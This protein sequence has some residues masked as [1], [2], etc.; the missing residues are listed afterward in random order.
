VYNKSGRNIVWIA[1]YPKSGNT[2]F[3]IF[4]NNLFDGDQTTAD[5]NNLHHTPIASSRILF[6]EVSGISSSDLTMKEIDNIR[7]EVYRKISGANRNILYYKVHDAWKNNSKNEPVFPLDV[8]K[9]VIYIIRDP[10]DIAVSYAY[11]SNRGYKNVVSNM[12]DPKYSLCDKTDRLQNQLRQE[13]KSWSEHVISWVRESRLPVFVIRYEDMIKNDRREFQ[14]AVDFLGLTY[15]EERVKFAVKHSK[16]ELLHNLENS[17]G[18]KEKP[19]KM[20]SFFRSGKVGD[21]KDRLSGRLVNQLILD[22]GPVMEQFGYLV[23]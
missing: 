9:A 19:L 1:S 23:E 4:L 16:F 17:M 18:F 20:E 12:A 22:H 15:Q 10:R 7:P 13:L 3:R 11:H 2:W 21:W 6:D 5:I 14:K 8:T